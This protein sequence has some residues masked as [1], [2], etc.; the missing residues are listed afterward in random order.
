MTQIQDAASVMFL[1]LALSCVT[2]VQL[3]HKLL[4]GS[5]QMIQ[6]NPLPHKV[7]GAAKSENTAIP[8]IQ[9]GS[10]ATHIEVQL[11]YPTTGWLA[12]GLSPTGG[13]DQSDVVF[14]YVDDRTGE[15]VIQVRHERSSDAPS[16]LCLNHL[17][18][19]DQKLEND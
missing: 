3:D 2:A 1:L 11:T 6:A 5:M 14:G 19:K 4:L 7:V 12:L 16:G 18:E 10:N 15:V 13:M 17:I 9:W 8:Q